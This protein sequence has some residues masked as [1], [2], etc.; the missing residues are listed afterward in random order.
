MQL[1]WQTAAVLVIV[2]LAAI[3]IS[4]L[5]WLTLARKKA[6]A[7]GGCK[8]CAANAANPVGPVVEIAPQ[9]ARPGQHVGDGLH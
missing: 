9:G 2:A 4:R 3:Y 8:S 6:A 7:C 5:A 1:D